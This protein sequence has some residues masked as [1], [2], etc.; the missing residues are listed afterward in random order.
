MTSYEMYKFVNDY[1]VADSKI[2]SLEDIA[3]IEAAGELECGDSSLDER[4]Q[5]LVDKID[6]QTDWDS[7]KWLEQ[8][9]GE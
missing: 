2:L 4:M 3:L 9:K 6:D 8:H 5:V 7:E 1:W